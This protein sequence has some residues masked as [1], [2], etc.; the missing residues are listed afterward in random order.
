MP[1]LL[2]PLLSDKKRYS[3]S[4]DDLVCPLGD[5]F[6]FKVVLIWLFMVFPYWL[7]VTSLVF[8]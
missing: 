5:K 3:G 2:L 1:A 8:S 6:Y 7:S 4:P